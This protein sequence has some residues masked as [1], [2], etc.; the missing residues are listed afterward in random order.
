MLPH[1]SGAAPHGHPWEAISQQR[2]YHPL[3]SVTMR[4]K[5]LRIFPQHCELGYEKK[6]E[7]HAFIPII[8]NMIGINRPCGYPQG[9]IMASESPPDIRRISVCDSEKKRESN[10]YVTYPNRQ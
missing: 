3:Q 8:Q 10:I 9:S 2:V 5:M 6:N 1:I 7:S 4:G